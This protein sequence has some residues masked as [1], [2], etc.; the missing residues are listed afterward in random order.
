MRRISIAAAVLVLMG[1]AGIAPVVAAPWDGVYIGLQL[2]NTWGET[3]LPFGNIGSPAVTPQGELK[4]GSVNAGAHAGYDMPFD[5]FVV[6]ALVDYNFIAL[7]DD[8]NA[9]GGD[10][11]GLKID[12]IF[13]VRARGGWRVTQGTLLYATVGGAW[14]GGSATAPAQNV[15]IDFSGFTYGLGAEF[16]VGEDATFGVEWRRFELDGEDAAF[17]LVGRHEEF[18]P[19]LDTVQIHLNYYFSGLFAG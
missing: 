13:T 10:R 9:L 5:Q 15:D 1:S 3:D 19:D 14:M 7:E 17:P 11:N 18:D 16:A 6:G 4:L 8:D 2:G 12:S